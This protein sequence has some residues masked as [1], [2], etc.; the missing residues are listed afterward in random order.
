MSKYVLVD[1]VS[2]FRMRYVIEVPDDHN[3]REVPCSAIQWAEDT[4]SSEEA[5]EFSQ[6]HIG[7]LIVS[8]REVTKDEIIELCDTDNYYCSSWPNEQKLNVFVTHDKKANEE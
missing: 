7:E 3:E 5:R 4:V 2:Q 1:T 6:L 8:S